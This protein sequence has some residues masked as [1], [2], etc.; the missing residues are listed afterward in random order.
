MGGGSTLFSG[1]DATSIM[2][3]A[4]SWVT[5]FEPILVVVVGVGL[6]FAIVRFVKHLFF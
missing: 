6:G 1:L 2:A 4:T 3:S 5:P